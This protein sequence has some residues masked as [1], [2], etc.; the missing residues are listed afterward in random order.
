[1]SIAGSSV[2]GVSLLSDGADSASAVL[3]VSSRSNCGGVD[4]AADEPGYT[5]D[6]YSM[7]TAETVRGGQEDRLSV[8]RDVSPMNVDREEEE[9]AGSGRGRSGAGSLSR[10]TARLTTAAS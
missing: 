3:S 6:Y 4:A 1:M 7:E 10:S 2:D 8:R 9:A 5:T